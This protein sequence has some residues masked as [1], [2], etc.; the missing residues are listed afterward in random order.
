M[1]LPPFSQSDFEA[2]LKTMSAAAEV[3]WTPSIPDANL[4]FLFERAPVCFAQL[5]LRGAIKSVNPA[6]RRLLGESR[7][8]ERYRLTDLIDPELASDCELLLQETFDGKRESFQLEN[9]SRPDNL[10]RMRWTVWR[11]SG[12]GRPDYALA[13]VEQFQDT[14]SEERLCQG[15]RLESVGRLAAGVA[16][17][18]NN[19]LTGV[20]LYCDLLLANLQGHEARKYAE[21]IRSAGT[22]AAVVVRQL[23]D[24]ARPKA[25]QPRPLC[26]NEVVEAE[27]ELL[28]R[29][30]GEKI[31][32]ELRLDPELALVR[33]DRSEAQR[34]L[35]NL[36]LNAR[37]AMPDC[38]RIVIETNNCEIGILQQHSSE[39][40]LPCVLL[41]VSDDG[42]GMNAAT[43]A[44]M[45]EAFFTTKGAKG[46]GL[47]LAGVQEIVSANGGLIYVDSAPG[48]GTRVRVL[49]PLAAESDADSEITEA[50][51]RTASEATTT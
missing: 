28:S 44:H 49:L 21:Q 17:D 38:G 2:D 3:F 18:F 4:R 27:R 12:W 23:L 51:L 13:L 47:G 43:R 10:A 9:R 16:H 46:T 48:K 1:A 24:V 6:L 41:V 26:L 32:V 33:L 15:M 14:E 37:D 19:L 11:V 42:I 31:D 8:F 22:Q 36:V 29:L 50:P 25:L 20:L 35:L 39:T 30:V 5:D 45:F 34:I 40:R 7:E